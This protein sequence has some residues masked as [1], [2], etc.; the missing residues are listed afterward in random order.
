MS[1][2]LGKY[3]VLEEIGRGGMAVV[4]RA[5]Q[6]SLDRIVAIKEL[7]I[8]RT[9]SDPKALARFQLE[10]KAAASLDHPCIITIHDFWERS[11]KAYIAMEFV[12]GLELKEVLHFLGS[13]DPVTAARIGIE[14]CHA[15]SY[16]HERGLIHRDIKPGNVMLS[17]LGQVKLADFG[18]V[19][20]TGSTD[21][22]TTGQVIGTPSYMSPEQIRGEQL[23]PASDIFS[24]GV[25]MYE[26]VTG[27]KPFQGPSD[28]A[29][30][31]AII[32]RRPAR[33]RRLA[34]EVPRRLA[35]VIMKCLRKKPGRR[36]LTMNDVAE[37][38][39]GSLP[40]KAQEGNE[41]VSALVAAT[42]R[43]G[44]GDVTLPIKTG[45]RDSGRGLQY[46]LTMVAAA[47]LFVALVLWPR[48]P[49]P[50][51]PVNV[52]AV[53]APGMTT[54][55]IHAYPWAEVFLDGESLGFTPRAEPFEVKEG[56]HTLVLRNPRLG[57]RFVDLDLAAGRPETISVDLLEGER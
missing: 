7:D 43:A 21:L 28:V 31:H 15:L 52:P 13:V 30:T 54:L 41:A 34:P 24:L 50:E 23:G 39:S 4:Y 42:S 8:A 3:R 11:S 2:K 12:D 10:A 22:T 35:R 36:Y 56:N 57:E 1:K 40:R 19:L 44:S 26:M 18:I 27:V 49:V 51:P 53:Q 5:R 25:V 16:A 33:I 32:H 45:K 37:A 47:V 9:G 55:A 29:V 48:G 38:L 46:V 6:E 14:L 17:S 20:V